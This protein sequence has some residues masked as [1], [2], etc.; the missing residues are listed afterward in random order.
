MNHTHTTTHTTRKALTLAMAAAALALTTA[1]A[2]ASPAADGQLIA[3]P[4]PDGV[5]WIPE[6]TGSSGFVS[7]GLDSRLD[8]FTTF[9]CEGGGTIEVTFHLADHPDR[10]PAPFTLNCPTGDPASIT[11]PLGPALSGGFVA[12]V[13]TSTPTTRWGATVTQPE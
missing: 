7:G 4:G 5:I 9:A 13:T 6:V 1:P 10:D 11:L 3:Y 12:T 8:T 2:H